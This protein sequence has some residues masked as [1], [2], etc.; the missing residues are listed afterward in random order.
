STGGRCAPSPPTTTS[1]RTSGGSTASTATSTDPCH[2]PACHPL[3]RR[4]ETGTGARN[5]TT[6]RGVSGAGLAALGSQPSCQAR[7]W[8]GPT[9]IRYSP[10]LSRLKV[11]S[12]ASSVHWVSPVRAARPTSCRDSTVMVP[13]D[14]VVSL[15]RNIASVSV[16]PTHGHSGQV[17][18]DCQSNS[19]V[20]V[21]RPVSFGGPLVP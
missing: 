12:G 10:S 14:S 13:E 8:A 3:R 16:S 15:L 17:P 20:A 6:T 1:S 2:P 21:S 9:A 18:G 7:S 5:N 19:P 4:A 11:D